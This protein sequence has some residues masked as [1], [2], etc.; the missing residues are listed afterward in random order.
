MRIGYRALAACLAF[1][2]TALGGCN[3][4]TTGLYGSAAEEADQ[5][6]LAATGGGG[7]SGPV[8]MNMD[9]DEE[10]PQVN[11]PSGAS[12]YASYAGAPDAGNVRFQA[13]I[14]DFA[15]E[16][17]LSAGNNVTIRI[18]VEGRVILGSKGSPGT[19]PAPLTITVRDRSG[20]TVASRGQRLSVT[21]PAGD[22]QGKFR[23]VE[24]AIVV[25]ISPDKP[26]SSY[27]ILVGFQEG[28]GTGR[29]RRG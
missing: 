26:L 8:R 9:P 24:D 20:A 5:Q 15:R 29:K 2:A 22:T 6:Q 16:C 21:V 4:V 7:A 19:Y 10:C 28:G 11:V 1:G 18:G 17:T 3:S 14:S 27:E 12:S 13:R 25:P 23:I